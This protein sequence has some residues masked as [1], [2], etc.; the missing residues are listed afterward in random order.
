MAHYH[1]IHIK[2]TADGNWQFEAWARV[3][4]WYPLKHSVD[5]LPKAIDT[6][7][8]EL[9]L[10]VGSV[11]RGHLVLYENDVIGGRKGWKVVP[12][13]VVDDEA[14]RRRI[15]K[16]GEGWE[17]HVYPEN[18]IPLPV[19]LPSEVE[20]PANST[21]GNMRYNPLA[22]VLFK[23]GIR[24][25]NIHYWSV[26]PH[27]IEE[28]DAGTLPRCE[29][30]KET[31]VSSVAAL[32]SG[33]HTFR[34]L[35]LIVREDGRYFCT[36]ASSRIAME[37]DTDTNYEH[38]DHIST[39]VRPVPYARTKSDTWFQMQAQQALAFDSLFATL[40]EGATQKRSIRID[41]Q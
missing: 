31:S 37:L 7:A 27:T 33:A 41:Q 18:W 21:V 22:N 2:K 9:W 29:F 5:M 26:V 34:I 15:R 39:A 38:I 25:D 8:H 20:T 6:P 13:V 30:V 35:Q 12:Y 1:P 23:K 17:L 28:A 40:T 36:G 10:V 19:L 4:K 24:V 16:S 14:S 11:P 3:G 32:I